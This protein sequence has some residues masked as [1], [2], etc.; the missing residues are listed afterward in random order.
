[1]D[2]GNFLF[3]IVVS[4]SLNS[5][6]RSEVSCSQIFS[7][8]GIHEIDRWQFDRITQQPLDWASLTILEARGP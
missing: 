5:S 1:M 4:Q 3:G 7:N 2:T 6:L 8:S